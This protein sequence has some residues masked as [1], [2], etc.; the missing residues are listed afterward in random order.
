MKYQAHLHYCIIT[1]FKIIQVHM[2]RSPLQYITNI[3]VPTPS[4]EA[5]DSDDGKV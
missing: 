1:L 2:N 5:Q 3:K 4:S